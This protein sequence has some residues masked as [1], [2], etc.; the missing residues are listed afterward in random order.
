MK[1]SRMTLKSLFNV[2]RLDVI[3]IIIMIM[4]VNGCATKRMYSGP[5]LSTDQIAFLERGDLSQILRSIDKRQG[6]NFFLLNR[7]IE[8]LPGKHIVEI[9][10]ADK[11]KH[12]THL[13]TLTF[14][15]KPGIRYVIKSN[16]SGMNWYPRIVEKK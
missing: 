3:G 15:A 14:T 12:S 11:H 2:F 16:V 4:L 8:I 13:K 6:H 9:G 1:E 5:P 7:E 10:Y